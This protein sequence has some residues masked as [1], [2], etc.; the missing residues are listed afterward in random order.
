MFSTAVLGLFSIVVTALLLLSPSPSS[1]PLAA[2][3]HTA[4]RAPSALPTAPPDIGAMQLK[5]ADDYTQALD[6]QSFL[7]SIPPPPPPVQTPSQSLAPQQSSSS[8]SNPGGF[9]SCVRNR[10]SGGDYAIHE[11]SGASSAAGAYQFL[12]S[13]WN[14]TA[15]AAGR[16]DL[17]GVDPANASPADQ[18]AMAQSLY[19]SQGTSPWAG[20]GC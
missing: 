18:D 2:A 12:P 19:G 7:A 5:A 16:Q 4:L 1:A 3:P 14:S 20:D 15:A 11:L 13:T 6:V 17:V 9:L 10:E 8:N